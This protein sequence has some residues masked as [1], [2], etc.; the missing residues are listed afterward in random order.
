[1]PFAATWMD[2]EI[3]I[4]SKVRKDKYHI[5]HMW[6]LKNNTNE[7]I[8]KTETDSDMESRHGPLGTGDDCSKEKLTMKKLEMKVF[9]SSLSSALP[10]T[11]SRL[12]IPHSDGL[13]I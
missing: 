3:I 8:Y 10:D 9:L 13:I 12:P 4:L 11:G 2:V 7:S 5:G 6:N 1:M